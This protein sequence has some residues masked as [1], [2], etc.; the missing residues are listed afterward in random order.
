MRKLWLSWDIEKVGGGWSVI[1]RDWRYFLESKSQPS[2]PPLPPVALTPTAIFIVFFALLWWWNSCRFLCPEN[3]TGLKI[4]GW[5]V[6]LGSLGIC[7]NVCFFSKAR[8]QFLLGQCISDRGIWIYS[9][10]LY[11]LRLEL[12][13][14]NRKCAEFEKDM[15]YVT[16]IKNQAYQPTSRWM[17]SFENIALTALLGATYSDWGQVREIV[18]HYCSPRPNQN[19]FNGSKLNYLLRILKMS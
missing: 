5:R 2:P 8:L 15:I 4:W 9:G 14:V 10:K 12:A 6:L 11:K 1:P 17:I 13:G 18:G 7:Q 16:L 3:A 19:M